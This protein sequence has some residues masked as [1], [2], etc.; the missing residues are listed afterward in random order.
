MTFQNLSSSLATTSLSL[1]LRTFE[2]P[3]KLIDEI[4][5]FSPLLTSISTSKL[6]SSIFFIFVSTLALLKTIEEY[7]DLILSIS[8]TK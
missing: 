8:F 7:R 5:V 6:F 3:M 1:L 4:F 2:L